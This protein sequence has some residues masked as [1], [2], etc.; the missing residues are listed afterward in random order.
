MGAVVLALVY[1][2]LFLGNDAV[3]FLFGEDGPVEYLGAAGLFVAAICFF[4]AFIR[5]RRARTGLIL[6]L[7]LL[8]LAAVFL[9]GAGEEVSWGQRIFG[10]ETPESIA[11]AN[12]QDEITVHNLTLFNDMLELERLFQIF[13]FG[14]AILIPVACALSE[15]VRAFATRVIPVFPLWVAALFLIQ[16][17]IAEAVEL[18]HNADATIYAGT[19]DF[20]TNRFEL[21]ETLVAVLFALG[22]YMVVR[23]LSAGRSASQSRVRGLRR[24]VRE[25]RS[26]HA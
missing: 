14:F 7:S 19:N 20:S 3:D 11:E 8:V 26:R 9:F 24:P 21:T 15:G 18:A 1:G 12:K 23:E 25:P 2:L 16:Q 17:L 13:W 5:A 10:V 22:A 4:V 6:K